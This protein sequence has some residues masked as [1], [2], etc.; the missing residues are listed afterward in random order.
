MP[1]SFIRAASLVIML[2]FCAIP[3]FSEII[4][5]TGLFAEEVRWLADNVAKETRDEFLFR[6]SGINAYA[7]SKPPEVGDVEVFNTLNIR[8]KTNVKIRA[9]LKKI[10][11]HCYVYLQ[12]G[13][14]V[15]AKAIAR[16]VSE[17]DG[18]IYPRTRS[19]FGSEWNPGID[20]DPRITLLLLDIQD[21]Y[22][23]QQGR[24]GY[25]AGYFYAGDC[26]NR[27]KKAE[28]NEREML[29]LDIYP[30][31]PGSTE[32]M[33]VVAHEFQHMIHWNNDPKEFTWVNES[34]S[35]LSQFLCGYGHPPQVQAFIRNPH[36]NLAAWSDDDMI[37]NYGHVYL[38]AYYISTRIASTDERRRAFVRRMVAQTSQGFSG[39]NA[40]IEKQGIKNDVRNLFR[41]FCLAN[42]LNDDRVERGAYG[43]DNPLAKLALRPDL[44]LDKPPFEV[45]GRVKCWSARAIQ[46]NSASF[47]GR[48]V[49]V[50]FA[51]QKVTAGNYSN[52]FDVALVT[53]SSDRKHLPVINWLDINSEY[54]SVHRSKVSSVHDRMMMLVVNRGPA[55]MKV[56]Q[57]FARG[58]A[59]AA[60]TFAIRLPSS[61]TTAAPRVAS[62]GSSRRTTARPDRARS[63]S[64]IEEIA[65]SPGLEESAGSVLS[66]RGTAEEPLAAV[67]F[68]FGF[69]KIA[70][71]EDTI[72]DAIR[73]DIAEDDYKLVEEFVKAYTSAS[74]LEKS[75]LHTLRSRV[76]DIL[77][78][79][80]LQGSARA[81]AFISQF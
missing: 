10:G 78:F 13:K 77:K 19:M 5:A 36:N 16:I 17:F 47:R 39:L 22:N 69:Q 35:Q 23:P 58:S 67:E 2:S 26:Y 14:K 20:G 54:K 80:Q 24:R 31:V 51:G 53:Y 57:A 45:K 21:N 68:D 79:E 64:M 60:F 62:A 7:D 59:P 12:E 6:T 75:R 50:L 30:S 18:R 71:A 29:Y 28:S 48:E 52:S 1:R 41:S 44:R 38:W 8:S 46:I 49:S 73:E 65:R 81:E 43:Y 25:T 4:D 63:R 34:L 15:D 27:K 72:I 40:A 74:D 76:L 61:S 33:S 70:D 37:A 32:F 56:E 3:A 66:S 11:K 42:Y 9:Q 55:V